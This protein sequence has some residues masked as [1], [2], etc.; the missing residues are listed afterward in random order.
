MPS[1]NTSGSQLIQD[2]DN[3][4]T[5][6]TISVAG[7]YQLALDL[8]DVANGETV[9]ARIKGKVR[10]AAGD[11]AREFYQAAFS[12]IQ[13]VPNKLSIPVVIAHTQGH[14]FTLETSGAS[15]DITIPWAVY[16]LS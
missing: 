12:H 8:S 3:E 14:T 6:A 2:T 11:T 5:L 13:G 7:T 9:I 15:V 10:D 16:D 1:V 4:V